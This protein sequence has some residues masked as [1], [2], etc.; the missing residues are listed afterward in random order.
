MSDKKQENKAASYREK[1][2]AAGYV[3]SSVWIHTDV[4][5]K[6]D[7]LQALYGN[8]SE[9]IEHA[10]EALIKELGRKRN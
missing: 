8:R 5:K 1:M 10:M 6:I 9:V 2:R 7:G 3:K 4:L